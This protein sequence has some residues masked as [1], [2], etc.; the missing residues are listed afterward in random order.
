[1]NVFAVGLNSGQDKGI[2]LLQKYYPNIYKLEDNVILVACNELT[3]DVVDN[4]ALTKSK[5]DEGVRG[6]VFS[7]NGFYT[8]FAK[9]SLWE[10]LGDIEGN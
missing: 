6:A 7:L 10:W 4:V 5:E 9:P 2:S 3:S 1:M 8:G